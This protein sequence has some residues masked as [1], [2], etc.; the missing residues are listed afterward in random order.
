MTIYTNPGVI[1]SRISSAKNNLVTPACMQ[2]DISM[3][4]Y[5]R[6]SRMPFLQIFTEHMQPVV[7]RQM[8]WILMICC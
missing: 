2:S 6:S 1:A 8:Q 4:E 3:Q 5:D 7:S